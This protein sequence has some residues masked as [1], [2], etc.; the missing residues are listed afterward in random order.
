MI[1][2]IA[3]AFIMFHRN[4]ILS[5]EEFIL[6]GKMANLTLSKMQDVCTVF[7]QALELKLNTPKSFQYFVISENILNPSVNAEDLERLIVRIERLPALP[8]TLS[9][10]LFY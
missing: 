9:E 6:P 2:Y 1:F 5:S 10:L 3:T 8:L 4:E 7:V